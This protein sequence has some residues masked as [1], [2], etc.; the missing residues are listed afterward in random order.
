M[1]DITMCKSEGCPL[2]DTCYRKQAKS[3][4]YMQSYAYFLKEDKTCEYYWK[5][6]N[7][8]NNEKP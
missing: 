4:E 3:N 8:Q 1:A 6:S 2:A 5:T 7:K